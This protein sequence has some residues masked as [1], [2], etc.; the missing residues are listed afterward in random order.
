MELVLDIPY[1]PTADYK[2]LET[3]NAGRKLR[4][5][6]KVK[7]KQTQHHHSPLTDQQKLDVLD[8]INKIKSRI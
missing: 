4:W 7:Y 5:R 3:P 8:R 6:P 1:F 2:N